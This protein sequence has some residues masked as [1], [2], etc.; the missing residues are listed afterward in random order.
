MKILMSMLTLS[1]I[2][3]GCEGFTIKNDVRRVWSRHFNKC[4][5]QTYSFREVEN[6]TD[7]IPC[8]EYFVPILE[9][10]TK[11][12]NKEKFRI[13]YPEKCYSLPNTE[14]CDDLVGF[15]KDSWAENIT[16]H[17]RETKAYMEDKLK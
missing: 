14:Y 17:G 2:F 16:P 3:S 5:C 9:K 13:K 4:L 1:L 11:E 8:E 6:L 7:F 10:Y 12:C 15:S